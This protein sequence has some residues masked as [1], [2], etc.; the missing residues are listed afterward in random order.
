MIHKSATWIGWVRLTRVETG[1][2]CCAHA[3]LKHRETSRCWLK[4]GLADSVADGLRNAAG[5]VTA[6][7][8]PRSRWKYPGDNLDRQTLHLATEAQPDA[9]AAWNAASWWI[10]HSAN[11]HCE[12]R[13]GLISAIGLGSKPEAQ[14]A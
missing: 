8:E 13:R 10:E 12:R 5:T 4:P 1:A 3:V 14:E 9:D 6:M 7:I 2:A 11:G